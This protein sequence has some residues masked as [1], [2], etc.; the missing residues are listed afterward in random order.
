MRLFIAIALDECIKTKLSE[1]QETVK[2]MSVKGKYTAPD[3]FH[4]T[5]YF[6]GEVSEARSEEI[7]SAVK[8]VADQS[9]GFELTL[10]YLG[11]FQKKERHILWVGVNGY[12]DPLYKMNFKLRSELE[13]ESLSEGDMDYTPHIT[14]GRQIIL[15]RPFDEFKQHVDVTGTPLRVNSISLMES[16]REEGELVY[17]SI[18]TRSLKQSSDIGREGTDSER[19]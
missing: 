5:L 19:P 9:S 11:H 13:K 18:Y 6:I 8:K 16:K 4:L 12:T 7:K 1:I 2:R 3:N 17:K 10:E 14:L 15:P